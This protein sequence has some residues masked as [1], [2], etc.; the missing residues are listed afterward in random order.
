MLRE[1][2]PVIIVALPLLIGLIDLALFYTG[3]NEATISAIMLDIR[4]SRPLVALST[5]YSAG[6][7]FGHLFFPEFT[8]KSPPPHE[9]IA[10]MV[11]ILSPTIYALILI[12]HANGSLEAHRR[13][14]EA[15]GQLLFAVYM[16]LALIAGGLA[17][18]FGLPQHVVPMGAP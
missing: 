18:K 9:V 15:G 5:S 10:R 2:T 8:D 11:V 16:N 17:G 14:L 3:G 7:L 12:G 1:W 4:T 6:V 13:A